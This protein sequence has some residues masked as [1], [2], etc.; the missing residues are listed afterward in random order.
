M[1]S[2]A[3]IRSV[4]RR[5]NPAETMTT[6]FAGEA[7]D[8]RQDELTVRVRALSNEEARSYV[9]TSTARAGVQ[10]V[11]IQTQNDSDTS[12]RYAPILTDP[13]RLRG[14]WRIRAL[15]PRSGARVPGSRGAAVLKTWFPVDQPR[16]GA[17]AHPLHRAPD[18]LS[19]LRDE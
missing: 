14:N 6:H 5:S 19:R 9:G 4:V 17:L 8:Q 18:D 7:A 1:G 10:P 13:N 11:W 2:R 16:S 3:L 12:A 15:R